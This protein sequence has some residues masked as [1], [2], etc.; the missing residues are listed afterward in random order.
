M[1]RHIGSPTVHLATE[2][3]DMRKSINGLSLEYHQL[4]ETILGPSVCEAGVNGSVWWQ[5]VG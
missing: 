3:V 4:E 1:M 2:P 5:C